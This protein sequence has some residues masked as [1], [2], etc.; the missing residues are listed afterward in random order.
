[1]RQTILL[2][3]YVTCLCSCDSIIIQIENGQVR[4]EVV[5]FLNKTIDVFTGIR[6]GKPPIGDLRF[7]RPFKTENWSDVYDAI[8]EKNS[9]HQISIFGYGISKHISED[10]LFLNVWAPHN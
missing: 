7:K 8:T 4:G 2:L 10:C 3:F 6:Y 9:C 5:E 1:M